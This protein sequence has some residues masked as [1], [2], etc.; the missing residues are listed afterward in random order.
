MLRIFSSMPGK[1]KSRVWN[2]RSIS[3][4]S[5][6]HTI[7]V[8][9]CLRQWKWKAISPMT[10]Y[11]VT[12]LLCTSQMLSHLSKDF[13]YSTA[14]ELSKPSF[15]LYIYKQPDFLLTFKV[16]FSNSSLGFLKVLQSFSININRFF[17]HFGSSPCTRPFSKE[18]VFCL[19]SHLTLTYESFKH[20][21]A[22]K[23]SMS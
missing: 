9:G 8:F 18:C 20:K 16:V 17:I 7:V 2:E 23:S 14:E 1:V 13:P 22:P 5:R 19:L 3:L 10:I 15:L 11:N 4:N 12:T 6:L 21:N